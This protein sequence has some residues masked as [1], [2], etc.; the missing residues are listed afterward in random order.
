MTRKERHEHLDIFRLSKRRIE[1]DTSFTDALDRDA[2][3]KLITQ[4]LD[5]MIALL[6]DNDAQANANDQQLEEYRHLCNALAKATKLD[7][8]YYYDGRA[9]VKHLKSLLNK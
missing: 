7:A 4:M 2:L 6:V 8:G 3:L 5:G 9:L 1:T